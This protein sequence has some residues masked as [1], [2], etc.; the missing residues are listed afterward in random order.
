[1][2]HS[3]RILAPSGVS[4]AV[5][6]DQRSAGLLCKALPIR[7]AL[8]H[9]TLAGVEQAIDDGLANYGVFEQLEPAGRSD[10]RGHDHDATLVAVLQQATAYMALEH[11]TG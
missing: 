1:M 4:T 8:E 6:K 11:R 10:L 7:A 3:V 9:D 5:A 2:N